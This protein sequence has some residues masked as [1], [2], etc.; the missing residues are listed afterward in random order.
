MPNLYDRGC[1][2]PL[3]SRCSASSTK[4]AG[5]ALPDR[6]RRETALRCAPQCRHDRRGRLMEAVGFR[7]WTEVGRLPIVAHLAR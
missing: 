4:P 3:I 1:S 2:S 7:G 6:P 5:A